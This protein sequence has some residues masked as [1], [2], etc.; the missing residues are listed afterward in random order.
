MTTRALLCTLSFAVFALAQDPAANPL[1]ADANR[2]YQQIK[3]YIL[4]SADKM[5][6]EEFAF[7]PS[8]DVRSF[9]QLLVHVADANFGICAAAKDEKRQMG[10]LEKTVT[11]RDAIVKTLNESFTYCD[12][13]FS[14]MTDAKA[15]EKIKF[16]GREMTRLGVLNFVTM[17]DF[18][19]YGNLVTYMRM[20]K[21]VPPSSEPRQQ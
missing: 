15:Q 4:K 12:A 3:A 20:K 6:A 1:S 5:P 14:G 17:H 16:F 21:V 2:A 8:D 9:G 19:H 7:K 18:E 11:A 13:A 10:Q